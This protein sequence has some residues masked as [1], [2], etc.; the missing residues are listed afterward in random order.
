[1]ERLQP[2]QQAH[3]AAGNLRA[4]LRTLGRGLRAQV[5]HE[6]PRLGVVI[7]LRERERD[8]PLDRRRQLAHPRHL[9]LGR[10]EVFAERT[11]GRE[12]E[13]TGA[14]LTEHAADTEQLVFRRERSGDGLTVDRHVRD[15][16]ARREAERAGFDAF[17][18]D[19]RHRLDVFGCGGLVL[20]A[21]LPHHVAAHRAVRNLRADVEHL[22]RAVDRVEVLGVV[23]P[24]PLDALGERGAGDVLDA[25]H[26]TDEPRVL[27]GVNRR[28]TDAAVAHDDGGDAVP[29][30]RREHRVP[31]D[32]TVEVRVHVDEAGRDERAVGVDLLARLALDRADLGD[33]AV[34]DRDVGGAARS[35]RAVDD[36][37]A[38]DHEI[39]HANTFGSG[40]VRSGTKRT[41]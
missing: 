2:E 38:F 3:G 20:R 8:R 31:G 27:V 22:R 1:M 4:H 7:V 14:E 5:E 6:L 18:H 10:G 25:F 24:T 13:H 39:M 28:E 30:R 12:L 32:L 35:T 15:R 29:A 36:R 40:P 33:D 26:Q 21:P 41:L 23:L 37:T 11:R 9:A 19:A 16:A 34:G 17:A